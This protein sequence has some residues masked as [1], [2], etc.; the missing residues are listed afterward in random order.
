M[1]A[2]TVLD[3]SS[4]RRSSDTMEALESDSPLKVR[5]CT[6]GFKGP[7]L[8]YLTI[9]LGIILLARGLSG[10]GAVQPSPLSL[11]TKEGRRSLPLSLVNEQ[12]FVAL[13]DLAAAFQL[14]VRED[15]LG[16]ITVSYKG[17]TIVLPSDQALASVSGKLISLPAPPSRAGRRWLVP[18]EF[19]SRALA[20]IYDTRLELRKPSHL[21]IVGDLRVPRVT[22]RYEP[23]GAAARLTID[24]APR[25]TSTVS[26]DNVR[27]TIK[28]DAD[29]L[30]IATPP[31]PPAPATGPQ[32]VIAGVHLT[33][34]VTVAVDLGPKFAGFKASTQP[35][36]TTVR[37]VIELAST[38]VQT[39]AAAPVPAPLPAPDL[40]AL[41]QPVS[42]IRT[43]AIDPGHGGEDEGAKGEA[44]TKEKDLTLALARRIKAAIEA[45]LGIRVLLTRDD[46]RNVSLDDRAAVANNNK[47]DLFISLHASASPRASTG[48]ASIFSAAFDHGAEQTAPTALTPERL[49]AFGGGVRDI[50]LVPWDLA[51]IR[52]VDRSID[53]AKILEQQF[54][55][56]IALSQH[57]VE[58][59]PL[60][61]LES[62]NMP[63][64]LV[65]MGYL[66]NA[67]QEKQLAG[68][69]FQNAFAQAVLDAVL[70]FRDLL[71]ESRRGASAAAGATR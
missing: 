67:E 33:D 42:S 21:L 52:H 58:Q 25:A 10:Q 19:V 65:E 14:V 46:D 11:L 61:V 4:L 5:S 40:S 59:A 37:L 55:D 44:G 50:E 13:D 71:Q 35:I 69:D 2:L 22:L 39:D 31:L 27:L 8:L 30:D 34:P 64:V 29:A 51:Q 38:Q 57:P 62:A 24:A 20:P 70:K 26:Q 9:F 49:P 28:F 48:G 41:S 23:L 66:T 47:V 1:I 60:R 63:A 56:R 7:A 45:R 6:G 16:A 15:A 43:I 32:G 12:E 36:D 54:Q 68:T 53:L 3:A 17:K 18:V